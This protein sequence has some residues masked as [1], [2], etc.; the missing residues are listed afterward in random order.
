MITLHYRE[1]NNRNDATSGPPSH[2]LQHALLDGRVGVHEGD[3]LQK[4]HRGNT[5]IIW[6]LPDTPIGC[7]FEGRQYTEKFRLH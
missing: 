1:M 7:R 3:S 6:E 2:Q 4:L 5:N